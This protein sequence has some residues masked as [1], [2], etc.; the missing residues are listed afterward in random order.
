MNVRS[1]SIR[2]VQLVATNFRF[3]VYSG[4]LAAGRMP[5]ARF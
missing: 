5:N 4:G 3:G 2:D 1:T